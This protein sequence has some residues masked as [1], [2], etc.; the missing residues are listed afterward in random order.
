MVDYK[1][2]FI[3]VVEQISR[4]HNTHSIYCD[5][6]TMAAIS[7]HNAIRRDDALEAEYLSIIKK[8]N[9]TEQH[10]FPQLLAIT[11]NA[12]EQRF[13]DFLGDVYM[14][15]DLGNVHQGQF[16]TPY[17]LSKMMAMMSQ[18]EDYNSREFFTLSEPAVGMGGMI[19]AYAEVMQENGINYQQKLWVQA[20][21]VS[22][23][24]IYGC[25]VQL[26]LLHIPAE[27]I[28]GN[29]LSGEVYRVLR[30]PAHYLGLWDSKLR[31]QLA[32]RQADK[33][34]DIPEPAIKL[35][36]DVQHY[37]VSPIAEQISFE[38]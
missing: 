6:V 11:V 8:Y 26:T 5:F 7:L 15:L 38:F 32:A 4:R 29:T 21:D 36:A 22:A 2:E 33:E 12:L 34:A 31:R 1:R 13:C 23:A 18:P 3:N 16:F 35:A 20:I 14:S 37:D 30:T 19:I 17:E 24:A 27:I 25:Y 28:H 10:L 9:R